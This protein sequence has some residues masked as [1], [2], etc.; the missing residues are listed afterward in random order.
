MDDLLVPLGLVKTRLL[1][2]SGLMEMKLIPLLHMP[3]VS[4]MF[5]VVDV[6]SLFTFN[7]Y[8]L[9]YLYFCQIGVDKVV[10]AGGIELSPV[11]RDDLLQEV[12]DGRELVYGL[13]HPVDGGKVLSKRWE[14]PGQARLWNY[15]Q[16][17]SA[18]ISHILSLSLSINFRNL[19]SVPCSCGRHK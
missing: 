16:M 8:I 2:L 14:D 9:Y 3:S 6:E 7:T 18:K 19:Q 15:S 10:D 13:L 4:S 17:T 1:V 5:H 12:S 11:F